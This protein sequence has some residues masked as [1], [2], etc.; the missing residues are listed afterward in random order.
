MPAATKVSLEEFLANPDTHYYDFHE[1]HNGEVVEVSPPTVEHML[2]QSRIEQLL[3]SVL[4]LE[5][6]ARSEFY[7]TLPTESRRV[8]VAA[9]RTNRLT[10]QKKK[11]FAGAPELVVEILSPSNTQLDVDHLR[12][13]CLREGTLQFWV[14]NMDLETVTVFRPGLSVAMYDRNAQA[15]SLSELVQNA[16]IPVDQVFGEES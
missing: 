9:V 7:L 8:D 14:I 2:L 4:G 3:E 5:Y 13:L 11:V 6:T 15:I 10:A 16:V 1:L 12:F